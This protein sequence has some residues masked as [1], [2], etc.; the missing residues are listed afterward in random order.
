M[1][2][3]FRCGITSRPAEILKEAPENQNGFISGHDRPFRM[4][5]NVVKMV[6]KHFFL[7]KFDWFYL[8]R[9][10]TVQAINLEKNMQPNI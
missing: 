1:L 9:K 3:P 10:Y 7:Q 8:Y 6:S 5:D 4:F 2:L